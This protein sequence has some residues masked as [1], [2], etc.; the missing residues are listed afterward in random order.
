MQINLEI[1]R[2]C[3]IPK[4]LPLLEDY[5][6][7][8]LF[9]MGGAG[10]GKSFFITQRII[11]RCIKE[12]IK[13]VVCRRYGTTLRNTCFSL[14]KDVL[15]KWKLTP[16]VKIRETDFNI[17]FPNG[18]EIIFLG[19]DEETK[20]LSLNNVGT[21][22]VEEAYEVPQ[23]MIEQLNLRMR[24]QNEGQQIIL[25]WNPISRSS[26]LYDFSQVNPPENSRFIHS[27]FEDNPFLSK[28][29]KDTIY[30]LR[31][32]NP[33]KWKVYGLGEW[34]TDPEGKVFQNWETANIDPNNLASLGY[35]HRCGMDFGFRDPS[36]VVESFYDRENKTIYV[37]QEFYKP[38]QQLD[39]LHSAIIEMGLGKAKIYMD[40]AEPRSIEYFRKQGIGAY[41]CV[42]GPDSVQARIAFLQNHKIIISTQ[43]QNVIREFEN[44]SYIRDKS[45][46]QTDKTTH[47][48]SHSIDAL[49]YAYSDIYAK[50]KLKTFDKSILGL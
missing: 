35:E 49:G 12:P 28:E 43:C 8:W 21:V 2:K 27:T 5:S 38:G 3:F 15:E 33:A 39:Q 48:Y 34:G 4:F 37:V 32:R 20:L 29:Y 1:D 22:F 45:G 42:K 17:R 30:E 11:V 31:V 41:P 19:L 46:Q 16:F 14:F 24:G 7:R 26:W 9:F 18:S 50:G 44:F 6:N 23:N 25:A 40:S 10:S 47:E 13:V 36:A